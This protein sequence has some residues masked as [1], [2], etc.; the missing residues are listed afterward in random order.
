MLVLSTD[1]ECVHHEKL[2]KLRWVEEQIDNKVVFFFADV[3]HLQIQNS[4]FEK[5]D[6]ESLNLQIRKSVRITGNYFNK[7]NDAAFIGKT[8]TKHNISL[9]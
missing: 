6:G 7:I 5:M 3:T 9:S 8:T 2:E 4:E 1:A